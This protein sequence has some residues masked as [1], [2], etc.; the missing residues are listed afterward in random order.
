MIFES[1]WKTKVKKSTH[2]PTQVEYA[3]ENQIGAYEGGGYV[4]KG[5]Y[6]S[7]PNSIMKSLSHDEFNYVSKKAIEKVVKFYSK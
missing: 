2:I 5:V 6:R 7:T 4:A 3:P 1:K